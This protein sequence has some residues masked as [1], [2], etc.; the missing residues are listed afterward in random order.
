[1]NNNKITYFVDEEL[2]PYDGSREILEVFEKEIDFRH[3]S[4]Y[5]YPD[6]HYKRGARVVNGMLICSN[7]AIYPACLGVDNCGF[8]FGRIRAASI[9]TIQ[10]SFENYSKLLKDYS[11][12]EPYSYN[13]IDEL[14]VKYLEKDFFSNTALY[15]FLGISTSKQAYKL[16]RKVLTK[17][18]KKSARMS[19]GS[20]GGGNH[21]FEVHQIQEVFKGN[22]DFK[23]GDFIFMLHSDSIGVGNLI[24]LMY[25]NLSEL[26]FSSKNIKGHIRKLFYRVLQIQYFLSTGIWFST[27][28]KAA[29]LLYSQKDYRTI[30]LHTKLGKYLIFTHNLAILFGEMNRNMIISNW[31]KTQN[32]DIET[33]A[34]HN[35]DSI[36]IMDSKVFHRN[37]VQFIGNAAYFILP[38]AMGN[39]SYIMENTFNREAF[40]SAN[41]GLGRIQDKHIAKEYYNEKDTG[42]EIE[43]NAIRL[44]RVGKGSLAEQNQ[45]AF[46]D[47]D[48]VIDIM[49]KFNLGKKL[50]KTKPIAIIKG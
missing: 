1:M 30:P 46:K 48:A 21:F 34:S 15:N 27:P 41:H 36:T 50:A 49:Q 5:I 9:N 6:V 37:G 16:C 42:N 2:I 44:Y 43:Q 11:A 14:F 12:F 3:T 40:Y 7:N 19:L 39:F 38:S 28:F 23:K 29:K 31:Q 33:I 26:D 4:I 24:N 18:M 32:I 35:H 8:T 25:S 20:L 45:K 13:D 47:A 10:K 22:S 17:R